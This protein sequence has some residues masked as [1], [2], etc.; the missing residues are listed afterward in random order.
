MPRIM[1]VSGLIYI[2]LKVSNGGLKR[3][4]IEAASIGVNNGIKG[5]KINLRNQK[6]LLKTRK[7]RM[8]MILTQMH[9][10]L[11]KP[12]VINGERMKI[13]TKNGMRNGV[14]TIEQ[15]KNKSG[16]INGKLI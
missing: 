8:L 11:K 1:M 5:S 14:R 3:K 15:T 7:M 16:V 6:K 12:T 2:N 9:L 13:Q 4:D 10:K